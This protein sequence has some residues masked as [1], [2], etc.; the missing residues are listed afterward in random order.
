[1][2]VDVS[3]VS[4]SEKE[5]GGSERRELEGMRDEE[6][7]SPEH[8]QETAGWAC[9]EGRRKGEGLGAFECGLCALL[10]R[11]PSCVLLCLRL[12][13]NPHLA[14][15]ALGLHSGG[16]NQARQ[17]CVRSGFAGRSI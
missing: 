4:A 3:E 1:M 10:L 12:A 5:E 13:R 15:H 14:R 11:L 17:G 9:A 16:R 2:C 8:S 6:H 7:E